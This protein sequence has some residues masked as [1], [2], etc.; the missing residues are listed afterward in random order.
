VRLDLW[1]R[2]TRSTRDLVEQQAA[3]LAAHR[4]LGLSGIEED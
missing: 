3:R 1:R 2:L 4:G